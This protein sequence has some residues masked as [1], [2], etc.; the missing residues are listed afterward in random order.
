LK[1][2]EGREEDGDIEPGKMEEMVQVVIN[3]GDENNLAQ[4]CFSFLSFFPSFLL[5]F[6]FLS[7]QLIQLF[8]QN[9]KLID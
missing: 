2:E 1:I 6:L 5:S 9:F 8:I 3:D 4:V 7:S